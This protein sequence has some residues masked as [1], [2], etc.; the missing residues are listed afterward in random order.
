MG[1]FAGKPI[2]S[3]DYS[4]CIHSFCG[5][6]YGLLRHNDQ[7]PSSRCTFLSLSA[8]NSPKTTILM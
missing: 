4:L 7:V 8:Y 2:E 6:K 3:E 5:Q 1:S